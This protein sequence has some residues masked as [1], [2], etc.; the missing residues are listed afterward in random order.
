MPAIDV[1]PINLARFGQN[2]RTARATLTDACGSL[3][4]PT[5]AN[6][7][8]LFTV[9]TG[10]CILTKVTGMPKGA[11]GVVPANSLVLYL[12]T[13]GINFS[14]MDSE[15]MASQTI[16]TNTKVVKTTFAEYSE[17]TPERLEGSAA[18]PLQ[19]WVGMQVAY[20]GGVDVKASYTDFL[21]A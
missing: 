8:K 20:A 6:L 13:D 15:T 12:T 19:V 3:A 14:L 17:A 16:A 21:V 11:A 5:V 9:P 1:Q 7:K 4:A 2:P 10:G 18:N